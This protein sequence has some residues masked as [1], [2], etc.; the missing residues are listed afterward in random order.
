MK[1]QVHP[2]SGT[3]ALNAIMD[4]V[5]LG[6]WIASV[7]ESTPSVM[8]RIF[9]EYKSERFS[10]VMEGFKQGQMLSKVNAKVCF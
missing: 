7:T 10:I 1:K 6:N 8:E 5:V 3:G 9:K 4:A 2:A